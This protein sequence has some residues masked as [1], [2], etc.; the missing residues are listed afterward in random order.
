MLWTI[1]L[2]FILA[3]IILFVG[4]PLIS[5]GV[6]FIVLGVS[7]LIGLCVNSIKH[8]MAWCAQQLI[9]LFNYLKIPEKD[10]GLALL[11]PIL[12]FVIIVYFIMI[13][14]K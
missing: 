10:W 14:A 6:G 1:A 2:G 11:G 9:K 5:I 7:Y 13:L 8:G 12:L 3:V 4:F